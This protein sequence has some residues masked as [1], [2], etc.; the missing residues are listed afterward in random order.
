[1]TLREHLVELRQRLVYVVLAFVV[2]AI[3]GLAFSSH[4]LQFFLGPAL[5]AVATHPTVQIVYATVTE[6]FMM[7]FRLAAYVGLILVSPVIIYQIVAYVSPGLTPVE[8]GYLLRVLPIGL[9][10]FLVG[11]TAAFML[12]LP[13]ALSFFLGYAGSEIG[14]I[15]PVSHLL[16]FTL[17]F[18]LPFGLVFE[19][20]LLA[21]VLAAMGILQ[22]GLLQRN[23]KYAILVIAVL[24]AV[25]TPPDLMSMIVMGLPM[26]LLYEISIWITWLTVRR[27]AA[28]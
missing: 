21:W 26:T 14:M 3:I 12:F 23:R 15:M 24:S 20:P 6:G 16:S 19:L 27:R 7:Q 1:M 25:L 18:V 4:A 10:L 2:A 5:K 9:V 8:R 17:S 28:A 11:C 13:F 22:P